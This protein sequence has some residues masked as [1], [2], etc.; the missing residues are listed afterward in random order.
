MDVAFP[1]AIRDAGVKK[2]G[3]GSGRTAQLLL[4]D[5]HLVGVEPRIVAQ[6][7]P[8]YRVILLAHAEKPAETH[9]GIDDA[10]GHLVDHYTF[11][12]TDLGAVAAPDRCAFNL[13]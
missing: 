10:T 12:R 4:G 3:V 5:I 11:N 13:V 9:H 1:T 7:I 6:G 8:R 2:A